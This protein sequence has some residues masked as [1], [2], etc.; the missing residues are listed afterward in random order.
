MALPRS[1][2]RLRRARQLWAVTLSSTFHITG[3]NPQAAADQIDNRCV[4]SWP[5]FA[6]RVVE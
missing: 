1:L 4:D 3:E 6:T 5:S 2:V